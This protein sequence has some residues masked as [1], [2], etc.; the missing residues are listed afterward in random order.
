MN[1]RLD[2]GVRRAC[3]C[4]PDYSVGLGGH[5]CQVGVYGGGAGA[6]RPQ[7]PPPFPSGG[8]PVAGARLDQDFGDDIIR[9]GSRSGHDGIVERSP[10]LAVTGDDVRR[11]AQDLIADDKL[12]LALIGPFD[13]A[14]RFEKLLD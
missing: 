5:G 1:S 7:P 14:D 4:N 12:R 3:A 9:A 6:G 8:F 13:D 10:A 2:F 11:V